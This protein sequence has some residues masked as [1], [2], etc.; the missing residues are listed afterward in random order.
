MK[1]APFAFTQPDDLAGLLLALGEHG[2]DARILAGG[3][4]LVPLMNLR[5][6]QPAM[7]I[8]LNRVDALDYIDVEKDRIVLGALVR[9]AQA[10]EDQAVRRHCPL[11]A[12]AL[13]YVGGQ[14]NR[15][16]GTVC[17]SL[18]HGDPLG[19]PPAAALALN[20]EMRIVGPRGRRVVPAGE[21]FLGVLETAIEADEMP[22]AVAVECA[23]GDE[24]SSFL[25]VGN[26]A[27]SFAVAG[28][29]LRLRFDAAGAVTLARV[30]MI[31]AGDR[32]QRVAGAE[33]ALT[34]R[35]LDEEAIAEAVARARAEVDPPSDVHA[36]ARHRRHVL[37][38]LLDR[39]LRR[40]A[41]GDGA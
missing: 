15:N 23:H 26:R 9:Q 13:S 11:L 39:G 20:A 38:V 32:A 41:K 17:G 35:V 7:L 37:G 33:A 5:M 30:A 25:E 19:E 28:L 18:A 14:S 1:P 6:V 24:R 31:G 16:R 3:Q 27:H 29:A 34:G 22:E 12:D 10:E 2:E 21:F 4:S 40:L 36:D 8:S